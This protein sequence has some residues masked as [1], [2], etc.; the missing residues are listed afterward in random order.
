MRR[1]IAIG[2]VNALALYGFAALSHAQA[3][4][5]IEIDFIA[6]AAVNVPLSPVLPILIA[7]LVTA[8]GIRA[9]RRRRAGGRLASWIAIGLAAVP[10]SYSLPTTWLAGDAHAAPP[11]N[12]FPLTSSPALV[13]VIPNSLPYH[14]TNATGGAIMLTAVKLVNVPNFFIDTNATTC[15]PGLRLAPGASCDV[16]LA[17]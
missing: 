16:V 1:W 3:G 12:P 9:L 4:P 5:Q 17:S 7:M 8:L 6:A 13:G 14:A 2:R 11:A 10:L 15:T